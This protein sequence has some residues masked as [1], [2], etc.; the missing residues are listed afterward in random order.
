[1][2][3]CGR[4]S[5]RVV[6]DVLD[7]SILIIE[8]PNLV[9]VNSKFLCID[10]KYTPNL[11]VPVKTLFIRKHPTSGTLEPLKDPEVL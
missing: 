10:C 2:C 11:K 1:M 8:N 6:V 9:C 4:V 7:V 5:L 3:E